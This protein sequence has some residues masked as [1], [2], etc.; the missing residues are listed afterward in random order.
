[1]YMKKTKIKQ[2]QDKTDP[3]YKTY[4][5]A[6]GKVLDERTKCKIPSD[7]DVE[8]AKHWVDENKK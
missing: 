4:A 5:L 7:A 8:R 2:K 6:Q 3:L 1:M